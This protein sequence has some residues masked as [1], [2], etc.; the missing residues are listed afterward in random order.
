MIRGRSKFK[1][2]NAELLL[3][4][5]CLIAHIS[6]AQQ[7]ADQKAMQLLE[8]AIGNALESNNVKI[9]FEAI[10]YD[11]KDPKEIFSAPANKIIK[12]RK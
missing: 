10:A 8:N 12:G 4:I 3:I 2:K 6:F 5:Y 9:S 11:L 1:I 7:D